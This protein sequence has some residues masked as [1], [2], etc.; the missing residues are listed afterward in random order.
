[1]VDDAADA[2]TKRLLQEVRGARIV[3]N[4]E[5]LGYL[6]SVN[7]GASVARGKWLVLF[8]NDTEVRPHWL[9]ALLDCANSSDDVGVVAPKYIYADGTLNEAGGII[10]RDGTGVNYGRGDVPTGFH[11]EYRREIDYGSAAALMVSADL[12]RKAGGFDE[13][14]VPMY[15]EDV[16]LCFEARERGL[17]VLYE[18]A[19]VVVHLEGATAGTDVAVGYKRYQ[20]QN[21]PKFV[22]KWRRRLDADHHRPSSVDVRIAANRHARKHVLVIDHRVPMW[23]RDAGSLRI[24]SIMRALIE[25]GAR[26]TFL[27][28]NLADIRPYTAGLQRMGV[29]VLYGA[30]DVNA[31]LDTLGPG[32]STVILCRPHPASHWLDLVREVAPAAKVIYD[33]VDLHWLRE[34]RRSN[35]AA[36][37]SAARAA[38]NGKPDVA[39]LSPRAKALR[40]LELAMIRSC[41]ATIVVS[42]RERI[43]VERD[44][45]DAS[46]LVLPTVHEVEQ[47]VSS[48]DDRRGILFV[49]G[50]EHLPNVDAAVCLVRQ[51]M[52]IVWDEL[53]DVQVSIVGSNPPAE[54][55]ALASPSVHVE[56]WVENLEPLLARSRLMLAPLRFGAGMKGKVT[57]CLAAGLPVVTT[58]VGAEGLISDDGP[59]SDPSGSL[60]LVGE[61]PPELAAAAIDLYTDDDL[62]RRLSFNGQAFIAENCSM[63]VISERLRDLLDDGSAAAASGAVRTA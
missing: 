17:R 2:E 47:R 37:P 46:L 43:Q 5:N 4:D 53:G 24:L 41:D 50:F 29:E 57:Q 9:S 44:V 32:L 22:A 11:Y 42:D 36:T 55:K 26:V 39:S 56:G 1:L 63:K 27:P 25:L 23:D 45:P 6:R 58:P 19:A 31:E 3:H 10:W 60:M 28:D 16:D 59:G 34:S 13:R 49:G 14:Y 12:W 7:K 15:Y 21:R 48:P 38:T 35:I 30:V 20:E 8:N 54:V 33:T 62:W 40:E 18:P 51:V 52:P 61:D